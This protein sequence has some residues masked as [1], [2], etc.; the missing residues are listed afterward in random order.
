VEQAGLFLVPLDEVRGWWRY[1]RLFADLLRARVQ[2]QRPGRVAELHRAAAAWY[3]ERGLAD[4]AVGH[5][6]AAGDTAWAAR[7]IEQYFDATL[8]LRSE[9][10]TAQR[11]L[12][13][14]RAE[15]VQARPRLLLA[16]VLLAA[17]LGRP[18]AMDGPVAA[19]ERALANS[20]PTAGS[21]SSHRPERPPAC[22]RI[23][24][25]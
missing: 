22:W 15:L 21:L 20:A 11:W 4:D 5:V 24:L 7:L 14:L 2:Q 16:Q 13:A 12:A 19:A 17:T 10:A 18:E 1:H 8:Y 9:G 23:S 25:Q 6:L 3:S